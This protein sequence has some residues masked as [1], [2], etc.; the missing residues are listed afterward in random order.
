MTRD[1]GQH[2]EQRALER[3][4]DRVLPLVEAHVVDRQGG[5][6]G[7][8]LGEVDVVAREGPLG[9]RHDER[10]RAD[11]APAGDQR[12]GQDRRAAEPLEGRDDVGVADDRLQHLGREVVEE[13]GACGRQ[14]LP[15]RGGRR[16]VPRVLGDARQVV[17]PAVAVPG[18]G[19]RHLAVLVD[20]A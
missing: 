16:Q 7:E 10:D 9:G 6:C 5:P 18:R 12:D 17:V 1:L 2:G 4:G 13:H 14:A 8:L 19:L 20:Q 15:A 11:D 3:V